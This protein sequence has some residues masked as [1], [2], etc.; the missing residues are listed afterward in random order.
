MTYFKGKA[1]VPN[2]VSFEKNTTQFTLVDEELKNISFKFENRTE[3][4]SEGV[5]RNVT[6][7]T[8]DYTDNQN[9]FRKNVRKA[10]YWYLLFILPIFAA[11]LLPFVIHLREKHWKLRKIGKKKEI[12][13]DEDV[14]GDFLDAM[15]FSIDY[16]VLSLQGA[17]S[18][19][20]E[21]MLAWKEFVE[22]ESSN[23]F[24]EK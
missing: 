24:T 17:I 9:V 4:S 8:L 16:R 15:H 20:E 11:C 1:N 6:A 14:D 7:G 10:P 5:L 13:N 3:N 19:V 23:T 21:S 2:I 12:D 22:C 18:D